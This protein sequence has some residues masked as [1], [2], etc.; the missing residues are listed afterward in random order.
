MKA[1]P[2]FGVSKDLL[3]ASIMIFRMWLLCGLKC[4]E[5]LIESKIEIETSA[6]LK[7]NEKNNN[8]RP[9]S[10][11]HFTVTF[12]IQNI[13]FCPQ[14]ANVFG[15]HSSSK[16]CSSFIWK[17]PAITMESNI[18]TPSL[19]LGETIAGAVVS[20][21]QCQNAWWHKEFYNNSDKQ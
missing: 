19:T 9:K 2:K 12:P 13:A 21:W 1:C 7:T 8:Q 10:C 17:N 15:W 14:S 11:L 6:Q 18:H 16:I 4:W 3:R 20:S 5:N